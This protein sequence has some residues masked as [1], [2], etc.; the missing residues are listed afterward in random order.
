V[1]RSI[2][3]Q[4]TEEQQLD[5]VST[6][7]SAL[8]MEVSSRSGNGQATVT[9]QVRSYERRQCVAPLSDASRVGRLPTRVHH[10]I[11]ESTMNRQTLH[12]ASLLVYTCTAI[13]LA[14]ASGSRYRL[15]SAPGPADGARPPHTIVFNE[16]TISTNFLTLIEFLRTDPSISRALDSDTPAQEPVLIIDNV[17]SDVTVL[18]LGRLD[19]TQV[20]RV[21]TLRSNEAWRRY[22]P[23]GYNGAII[24]ET[25]K[26]RR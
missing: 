22:G 26:G 2:E 18:T 24:V 3:T 6:R 16:R 19:M 23:R 20:R 13:V 17:L 1:I 8:D 5:R 9:R 21:T 12:Y 4:R 14:C 10:R 15:D 11:Q 25:I 7:S